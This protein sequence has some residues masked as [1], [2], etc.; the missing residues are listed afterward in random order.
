MS[1]SAPRHD[2]TSREQAGK[3]H[4]IGIDVGGTKIAGG[5]V[6]L[7]SGTVQAR[8][9][10]PTDPLRGGA[11]VL[12]DVTE[13]A[14][15]LL[16]DAHQQAIA[17]DGIGIG[18][19]ELVSPSGRIFSDYRIK[20]RGLDVAGSVRTSLDD[21]PVFVAS[22]VRAAAHAEAR[23][24]AGHRVSDFYYLTIG[25]GVSGVLV[26]DGRP[27]EGA[28][29]AALVIAN[30]RTLTRCPHCGKVAATI[31]EDV[32]SGP[33]IAGAWGRGGTAE[34]V[35]AAARAGDTAAIAAVEGAAFELGR[36]VAL[37]VNS[38]DPALVIVGGGLGS[39][40][41]PYFAALSDAIRAGLWDADERDLPIVRSA[42]GSDAGIIGAA[43]GANQRRTVETVV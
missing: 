22:D 30:G 42:L 2:G 20:W 18:V 8:R 3:R 39:A 26:H 21:L 25:T 29:G 41:G 5:I 31:A 28:R 4:A 24:G 35:L 12:W 7:G 10:I 38:L 37:L 36:I 43:V 6:D 34:D 40:P 14:R 17:P 32:A 13:M 1:E 23:F 19:A 27:Y 33:G 16:A 15:A 9:Q 11:E